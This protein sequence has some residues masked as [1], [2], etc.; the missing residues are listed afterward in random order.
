MELTQFLEIFTLVTGLIYM[1]MQVLQHKWMWYVNILTSG[2]ALIVACMSHIWASTLL[3]AYFVVMAIVGI[4]SWRKFGRKTEDKS[5]HIVRMSPNV[6]MFSIFGM[7]VVS[8]AICWLLFKTN[9]PNPVADGIA[10]AMSMVATWWLTRSYVEEWYMW[11]AADI[12][13]IWLFASQ[14]L[15]GM[16][17]LYSC[18]IISAIIGSIHWRRHGEIVG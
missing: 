4:I 17:A 12:I 18:Y 9:D 14:G 6:L 10:F 5:I 2:G 13:N 11:I 7:S 15:W 1:V 8:L 3:N 16:T